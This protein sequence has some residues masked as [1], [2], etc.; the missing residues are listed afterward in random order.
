MKL[1]IQMPW[2]QRVIKISL[3]KGH[4]LLAHTPPEDVTASCFKN[5]WSH[6]KITD[7]KISSLTLFPLSYCLGPYWEVLM[8]RWCWTR[9]PSR[10]PKLV[11]GCGLVFPFTKDSLTPTVS[12]SSRPHQQRSTGAINSSCKNVLFTQCVDVR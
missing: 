6:L 9:S 8:W 3:Q 4:F 11:P 7:H 1:N 12:L 10:T 2:T 5:H